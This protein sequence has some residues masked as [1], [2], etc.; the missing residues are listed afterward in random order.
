MAK[1]FLQGGPKSLKKFEFFTISRLYVHISQKLLK[2][3][4]YKQRMVKTFISPLSNCRMC[5]DPSLTGFYRMSQKLSDAIPVLRLT[6]IAT[7]PSAV[8]VFLS[9]AKF[10]R[11]CG[12]QTCA[13]SGIQ[14]STLAKGFLQGGPK[15]TKKFRIFDR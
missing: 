6:R 7:Q 9:V 14:P 8:S 4:A 10:S 15:V 12:A 5:K 3:E 11:V 13:H 2:I 1:A